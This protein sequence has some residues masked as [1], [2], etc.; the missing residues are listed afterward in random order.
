MKENV[1]ITGA[2]GQIGSVIAEALVAAGCRVV[3][4]VRSPD[5]VESLTRPGLTARVVVL[6]VEDDVNAFVDGI[7]P[8]PVAAILTVG[9]FA[10]GGFAETT[11]DQI[12]NM[13]RLNFDTAYHLV[14]RLLPLFEGRGG[15]Q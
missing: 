4:T 7:D 9:G 2:S 5:E 14:R 1:I 11:T 15:G 13:C 3:G 8:V 12:R 10:M 6:T